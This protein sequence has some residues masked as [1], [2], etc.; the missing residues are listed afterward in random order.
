MFKKKRKIN[1]LSARLRQQISLLRQLA[2][3]EQAK[4]QGVHSGPCHPGGELLSE[5]SVGRAAAQTLVGR[6]AAASASEWH[7]AAT[8]TTW[9]PK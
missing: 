6:P 9:A 7:A 2:H 1:P 8:T 3:L 4:S 5:H